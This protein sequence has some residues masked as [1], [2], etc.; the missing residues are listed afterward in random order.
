MFYNSFNLT[1]EEQ[2]IIRY[3][4]NVRKNENDYCELLKKCLMIYDSVFNENNE[5]N[6]EVDLNIR[7]PYIYDL[8]SMFN[9]KTGMYVLKKH[10]N[11][12]YVVMNKFN[13]MSETSLDLLNKTNKKRAIELLEDIAPL[14]SNLYISV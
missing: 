2:N 1:I 8:L 4:G 14:Y 3:T 13:E 5:Y 9:N 11:L 7:F 6:E 12:Y 10:K